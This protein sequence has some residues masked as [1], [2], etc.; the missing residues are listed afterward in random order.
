MKSIT[1]K[2]V[3]TVIVNMLLVCT[4]S[5]VMSV[6]SRFVSGVRHEGSVGAG[7]FAAV[8]F[9]IVAVVFI[10]EFVSM[11]RISSSTFHTMLIALFLMLYTALTPEMY[12]FYEFIGIPKYTAA[13]EIVGNI[14]FIGTE[15]STLSFFRYTY[16]TNKKPPFFPLIVTAAICAC[17]YSVPVPYYAKAAVHFVFLAAVTAYFVMLQAKTYMRG[18]DDVTFALTSAIFFSCAGMHT[19]TVMYYAGFVIYADGLSLIY[20]WLC[21]MCFAFIYLAFFIRTDRTASRAQDYRMQNEKLKMKVLTGQIKPHFIF[22]TLTT[23]KSMYHGDISSG[24]RALEMFSDYLRESLSLMDSEV[25]P[26]EQELNNISRYID[27][28]NMDRERPFNMIYDIDTTD[29]C[30]PAFSLQPFIE[31]AVK[32]SGVN[33]KDG[34]YIMISTSSDGERTKL[35]IADNGAGFETSAI[36]SGAH[37]INNACERF[38]LFFDTCP[39]VKSKISVGTEIT[40]FIRHNGKC[41]KNEDNCS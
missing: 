23:V 34:G 16:V 9:L 21:L 28:V 3:S 33:E 15:V 11:L 40:I 38:R 25:I 8:T 26:F 30:V 1:A 14:C 41:E 32:Y 19:A 2:R 12:S 37:G 20:T 4:G 22:N 7:I 29:F 24:D 10:V 18:V 13:G 39:V 27:F 17:L 35:T 31:N 6:C 36:K 5:I